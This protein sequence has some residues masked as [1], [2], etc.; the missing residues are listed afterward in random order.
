MASTPPSRNP[1][2]GGFLLM[3]A[4]LAGALIGAASGQPSLGVVIGFGVG[5]VIVAAIWLLDRRKS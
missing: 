5:V 2:A 3:L 4:L 1:L